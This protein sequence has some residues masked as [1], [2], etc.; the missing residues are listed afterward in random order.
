MG[1]AASSRPRLSVNAVVGIA[2]ALAVVCAAVALRSVLAAP[3]LMPWQLA[4]LLCMLPL[5]ELALLHI[6]F[7]GDA[8]SFT[9][10]EGCLLVGFAVV[11]PAWL[12]LLAGP[13]VAFVHLLKQRGLQKAAFNGAA[14]TIA[15][16]AA[17]ALLVTTTQAPYQLSN[18]ADALALG[19]AALVFSFTSALCTGI[20]VSVAQATSVAAVLVKNLRMVA[21]VSLG[22]LLCAAAVLFLAERSRATLFGIPPVM[23]A[24]L[25]VYRGYLRA[26]Q[27][28][29]IWRQLEAV[30]RE[31]NQLDEEKVAAAALLRSR[32]LFRT[33]DVDLLLHATASKPARVYELTEGVIRCA[34]IDALEARLQY[35]ESGRTVLQR[36]SVTGRRPM[37]TSLLSHLD[38]PEGPVGTLRLHFDGPVAL[39]EREHQVLGTFTHAVATT[40]LNV[41]LHEDV[42][43]EAV[44]QAHYASHDSLTGLANRLLLRQRTTDALE[45]GAPAALM[46]IDLDHFKE[47]NDTLGHAVG[48]VLL[49]Q[50]ARRLIRAVPQ[51]GLVARLGGDEFAILLTD[52]EHPSDAAVVA[53]RIL[54]ELAQ[55][56]D[57]QGLH[58]AV[59]G[60]IGVACYPHDAQDAEELFRRAD[61]AMYQAKADRGSWLRYDSLRDDSS[62]ERL[63]LVADLRAALDRH[64]LVVHYQQKRDLR[65]GLIVGAEALVRWQHPVRGL[66]QPGSFVGVAEQ[67]GLVRPFTLRVL[68]LAVA[69]CVTWDSPQD[70]PLSV[71]VNLGARSLLDRR[72]P[73][74]VME[75]LTRHGLP[76]SRLVLE[77]TETT[78]T[79]ELEVVE[80]VL[81]R[82]RRLGIEI[83]VDDF[84]TGHSSLSFLQRTAVHELKVDRS[85]VAGMLTNDNDRALVRATIQLAHS[86]GARAVGEGVESQAL[87]AALTSLGCDVAQGYHLGRPVPAEEFRAALAVSVATALPLPRAESDRHLSAVSS[88]SS[89]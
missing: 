50:V 73:E 51:D 39:S 86:L 53:E 84:G 45:S 8:L 60:S 9:W 5:S 72:L 4:L 12:V 10:G 78:A 57:H 42:R 15:A 68:E 62:I 22:N 59:E 20:V 52:L 30:A 55:P 14:F 65:S 81:G 18:P 37:T 74:D 66:L 56:V 89:A 80:D 28:R 63:A 27:E 7:G 25:L 83:S 76:P 41:A 17:A 1:S 44:K 71:A 67:S 19:A 75:V 36:P 79:S 6:R 29:D 31:L 64:E 34:P 46:L 70:T 43:A 48:D 23:L 87:V 26:S 88:I 32:E 38:G 24:V 77:I 16:A 11:S 54:A 35:A 82:L 21:L 69:E 40:L 49:Q 85:F 2:M 61:V 47:I 13:T 33:N 58:L 3:S